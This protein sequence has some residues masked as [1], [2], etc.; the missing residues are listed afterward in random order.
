MKE[1]S[2]ES[3]NEDRVDACTDHD[4][5][6]E[7]GE[8]TPE[9]NQPFA[10]AHRFRLEAHRLLD[11]STPGLQV[12]KKQQK[13]LSE[14]MGSAPQVRVGGSEA[15]RGEPS[16]PVLVAQNEVS[17]LKRLRQGFSVQGGAPVASRL[18]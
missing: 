17:G 14:L 15:T 18:R 16:T 8:E 5:P 11:L 7:A 3:G 10:P 1:T 4:N 2:L 6:Q 13:R 12:I 9:E